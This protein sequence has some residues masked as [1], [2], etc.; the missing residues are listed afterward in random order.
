MLCLFITFEDTALC[1]E[2][3]LVC[4]GS[5]EYLT[6]PIA[7]RSVPVCAFT[8]CKKC[9]SLCFH[10]L[11]CLFV[12][13]KCPAVAVWLVFLNVLFRFQMYS[14]GKDCSLFIWRC[15]HSLSEAFAELEEAR[16]AVSS[17]EDEDVEV[18]QEQSLGKSLCGI[19]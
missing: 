16:R 10:M 4:L 15:S 3:S 13:Y 2:Y 1:T 19:N 17:D 7:R 9:P 18:E 11:W 8:C 12:V 6:G 5:R 14:V